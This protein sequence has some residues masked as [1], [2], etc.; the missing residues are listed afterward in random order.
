MPLIFKA[1]RIFV[2]GAKT[3]ADIL[4]DFNLAGNR[5]AVDVNIKHR[6]KNYDLAAG[7]FDKVALG[8]DNILNS[9]IGGRHDQIFIGGNYPRRVSE[10][11]NAVA[12]EDCGQ[13]RGVGVN[14]HA[15]KQR[16]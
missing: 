11:I 6:Q 16:N 5:T 2:S 10:K 7:R 12:S 14:Q 9:A 8:V 15:D 4:L 3:S 1:D 13:N